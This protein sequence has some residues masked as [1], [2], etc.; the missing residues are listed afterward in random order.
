M[1]P[2]AFSL[3]IRSLSVVLVAV[4]AAAT[5]VAVPMFPAV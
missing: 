4:I 1:I 2:I 5:T 3:A